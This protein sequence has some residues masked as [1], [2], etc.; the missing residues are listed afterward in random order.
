MEYN[1]KFPPPIMFTVEYNATHTWQGDV[2]VG[3]SLKCVEKN[4]NKKVI[5]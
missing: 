2:H 4:I 1:A 5:N 3:A